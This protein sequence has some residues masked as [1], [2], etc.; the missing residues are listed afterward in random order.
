M[1]ILKADMDWP[2]P[3]LDRVFRDVEEW[4]MWWE[5]TSSKLSNY[6]LHRGNPS[7][8]PGI[9]GRAANA[10]RQFFGTDSG[11]EP[12]GEN[13]VRL[14]LP[15]AGDLFRMGASLLMASPPAF[16]VRR[17]DE[18]AEELT[19]DEAEIQTRLDETLNTP[20]AQST[21]RQAAESCNALGG[22]YL[23]LVWD[24]D[25]APHPFLDYVDSDHAIPEFKWGRLQAVTFWSTYKGKGDVIYRHMERY[26]PGAI[27]HTLWKGSTT[28]L[29]QQVPLT[30]HEETAGL[31][32]ILNQESQVLT[33]SDKIAAQY[34]ANVLPNPAWRHDPSLRSL[35]MSTI[36]NDVIPLLGAIDR[37]WSA[38]MTDMDL[39]RK[40]VIVS[41][42]LL[43]VRGHGKGSGFNQDQSIF[44]PIAE[45]LGEGTKPLLEVYEA[46]IRV[47][48]HL[49][50]VEALVREVLRRVGI[51]PMTFGLGSEVAVTATEVAAHTRDS[52][53]TRNTKATYWKP[54][55][56]HLGLVLLEVDRFNFD[57]ALPVTEE[58]VVELLWSSSIEATELERAQVAQ[59]LYNAKA[60]SIETRVR[61]AHPDWDGD[62]V[63]EEVSLILEQ[64]GGS[65][66]APTFGESSFGTPGG[67]QGVTDLD[68]GVA[69]ED[70]PQ[71]MDEEMVEET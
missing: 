47:E 15:V 58:T 1:T 2:P 49:R 37:A 38:L 12:V 48:E 3:A 27:E 14:H 22:V 67:D 68:G 30:D 60:A 17:E 8:R 5:G 4:S 62:R 33:G 45:Q 70:K 24:E 25:V 53:V 9:M 32:D 7:G 57:P 18:D 23:R 46:S 61:I 10:A 40:R 26:I 71:D 31:A 41:E 59:T 42:D 20:E 64:D 11:S 55:L 39:A 36:S 16:T 50:I 19:P 63:D 65:M 21:L 35:G 52:T 13:S 28:N 34:V 44:S 29:G 43:T 51:S 56:E 69:P 6:Y 54:A 66:E